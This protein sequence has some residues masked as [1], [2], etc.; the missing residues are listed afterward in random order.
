MD[1]RFSFSRLRS[2]AALAAALNVSKLSRSSLLVQTRAL[3]GAN[4]F[5]S[6]GQSMPFSSKP[7]LGN[8]VLRLE[9]VGECECVP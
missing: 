6:L 7:R 4:L 2:L 5:R 3:E 9:G 8:K 1:F